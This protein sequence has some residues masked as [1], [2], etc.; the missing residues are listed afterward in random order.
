MIVKQHTALYTNLDIEYNQA[1]SGKYEDLSVTDCWVNLP[2]QIVDYVNG[3]CIAGIKNNKISGFWRPMICFGSDSFQKEQIK[4]LYNICCNICYQDYLIDGNLSVISK[5]LLAKGYEVKP[6]YT[7]IIDLTK[8]V[9]ELHSDLR[10]SYKSLINKHRVYNCSV[11]PLKTLH[12]E[13]KGNTR[14]DSTWDI[15]EQMIIAKQAF[16][17]ASGAITQLTMIPDAAILVYYNEHCAYYASASAKIDSHHLI[18][19]AILKAKE[20]G[21]KSFEIGQQIYDGTEKEKGIS[22]FKTGWGG[23]TKMRLDL[24]KNK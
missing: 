10:K 12:L 16:C 2:S 7:Q 9:E 22:N 17:L 19:A 21:I 1:M 4:R 18:W 15:Q 3:K 23:Q 13:L 11:K 8:S 6:Y 14:P 5:Y 24:R 20:L